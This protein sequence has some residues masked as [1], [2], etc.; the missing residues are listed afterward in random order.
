M[1]GL[2]ESTINLSTSLKLFLSHSSLVTAKTEK[3]SQIRK[4]TVLTAK[5]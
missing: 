3:K 5:I 2:S 4:T 1:F